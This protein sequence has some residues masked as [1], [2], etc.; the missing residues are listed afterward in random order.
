MSSTPNSSPSATVE[1]NASIMIQKSLR[2]TRQRRRASATLTKPIT[3]AITI[4]A[5]TAMGMSENTSGTNTSNGATT[6]AVTTPE[7]CVRAPAASTIDERV[8]A[9][10]TIIPWKRPA[11]AFAAPRA[12]SSPSVVTS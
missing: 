7:N 8:T 9:P 3:A 6:S 12:T 10:V 5:S 1:T 11:D 2:L 4:P